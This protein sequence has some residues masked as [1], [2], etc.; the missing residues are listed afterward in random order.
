MTTGV[1]EDYSTATNTELVNYGFVKTN[2]YNKDETSI[3]INDALNA[4]NIITAEDD[5]VASTFRPTW[6]FT[7]PGVQLIDDPTSGN[8][9]MIINIPGV[10]EALK[11]KGGYDAATNIPDLDTSAVGIV[12]GDVYVVTVSGTFFT[13]T[14]EPGD[15]LIAEV[16]NPALESDW[17]IAQTNI[18]PASVQ[19]LYETNTV[20]TFDDI[21]VDGNVI[22]STQT[23]QDISVI[24]NGIGKV[25]MPS[26]QITGG[27]GAQG[28]FTWNADEET[29]DVDQGTTTLQL[30]QEIHYHVRNNS[31]VQI[32]NGEAVAITGTI[33]G[34]GRI[35][36]AKIVNDGNLE[37]FTY[38]GIATENISN[39]SD[40]K[41][42]FFGKIRGIQT[43]GVNYGETWNDGDFVYLSPTT[44]GALTNIPPV[45]P[46]Y[47]TYVA[48]VIN[49][50]ANGSLFVKGHM[51]EGFHE[52]HDVE[53]TSIA[54]KQL[55][56]YDAGNQRYENITLRSDSI[57]NGLSTGLISG[58]SITINGGNPALFDVSAGN[59]L[60]VNHSTVPATVTFVEWDAFTAQTLTNL[61]TSFATDIAIDVGGN[62]V[63]QNSYSR[64]ELRDVI[65]LG[66]IDHSNQSTIT[67]TFPISV[68]AFGP[69]VSVQDL[70]AAIGDINI[71]G[72]VYGPNIA[73][74]LTIDRSA[75]TIFA[76]G[77]NIQTNIKDP[78]IINTLSESPVSF[79]Y[80]FDDGTG[81]GDF[82][83]ADTTLIDP[84]QYDTGGGLAS[85]PPNNWTVQKLLLFPNSLKT[86]IQYG[87][88]VF[89]KKE[90]AIDSIANLA[91]TPNLRGVTSATT[92]GFLVI[93]QGAVNLT[94]DNEAVFIGANK[95]G[96]VG[97]AGS[98]S[99]AVWG[100]ITGTLS[101]QTDL[102]NAITVADNQ[103]VVGTG[104]GIEGTAALTF[105][106]AQG[107]LDLYRNGF[108]SSIFNSGGPLTIGSSNGALVVNTGTIQGAPTSGNPFVIA[109]S[110]GADDDHNLDLYAKGN[111]VIRFLNNVSSTA[112]LTVN[113]LIFQTGGGNVNN[114]TTTAFGAGDSGTL[115]TTQAI[116]TE[117][118]NYVPSSHLGGNQHIDW[119]NASDNFLTTGTATANRI[120]TAQFNTVGQSYYGT[121]FGG[122]ATAAGGVTIAATRSF[123]G[124][125]TGAGTG[126][127]TWIVNNSFVGSITTQ[128][129]AVTIADAAQMHIQAPT[130]TVNGTANI[131]NASTVKIVSAPSP[132]GTGTVTNLYALWVASGLSRFDGD[133]KQDSG[134]SHTWA[135]ASISETIGDAS[136]II[137]S[138]VKAHT[139]TSQVVTTANA[140]DPS[141]WLKINYLTGL[142]YHNGGANGIG[143]GIAENSNKVFGVDLLGNGT[144]TGNT[145]TIGAGNFP[146]LTL[147]GSR[148]DADEQSI[149]IID[150]YNSNRT[151]IA[152]QIKSAT[153]TGFPQA[154]YGQLIFSVHDG[155]D[156]IEAFRL[157]ENRNAT[158]S[159][160]VGISKHIHQTGFTQVVG[161]GAQ[162]IDWTNNNLQELT[163]NDNINIT[164]SF[165]AP[166]G[167]STLSLR[168]TQY[169][170]GG[171]TVT[172]PANVKWPGG[173]APTLSTGANAIDIISF[174]WDGA[175]YYGFADF[176]FS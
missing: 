88:E 40:G 43:N 34:S 57:P 156:L 96:V 35:T 110:G 54:N 1:T 142:S 165:T 135:Y 5:G 86:F 74:N 108:T 36:V 4:A 98:G 8:E 19:A 18:T 12:I 55:I 154:D 133:L 161:T 68:P 123:E 91:N 32:N 99:T 69:G 112:G 118:G 7:G 103:V 97:S 159:G 52:L 25:L 58:G 62:L 64:T 42:T 128:T 59:G 122:D 106:S 114:V 31:G 157:Q 162:T 163:V 143:T 124:G 104:T 173:T 29:I 119:T 90:E 6:N 140:T 155:G 171:Q 139:T 14:V 151:R 174:F 166:S 26:L 134:D 38:L 129:N 101:D 61:G 45:A 37:P 105:N 115:A 21:Q 87:K 82:S 107:E 148:G 95:F 81:G 111:G 167:P 65:F 176:N 169:N 100:A 67:Y 76:F 73:G 144:F 53:I 28:T 158:F 20:F 71:S 48:I 60:V 16:D 92:R 3:I 175:A 120:N 125:V 2:F 138:N 168:I 127:T 137:G 24:P 13:A 10:P 27:T 70:A 102:Q 79:G 117:L 41:I 47:K 66:G 150:F 147:N 164:L 22:S 84:D 126:N 33:G 141:Q 72:N 109:A 23:D 132:T 80:V 77:E 63:Q 51:N 153:R 75:G 46:A 113:N 17:T 94:L 39:S 93:K 56:H 160:N 145:F 152:G 121:A 170:P 44:P 116:A 172:W 89:N 146:T 78:H 149:G 49:A 30:G 130:L 131:T 50:A 9:K 136:T 15:L 83:L 85:V 11:Y